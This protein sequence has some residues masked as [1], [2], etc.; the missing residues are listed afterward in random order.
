MVETISAIDE[1]GN[2]FSARDCWC[3]LTAS[4]IRA[5]IRDSG[6]AEYVCA[7]D[8]EALQGLA[9]CTQLEGITP[10]LESSHAILPAIRGG[11]QLSCDDAIV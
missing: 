6:R 8:A 5:G 3:L 7:S 10:A 4:A 1:S 9:L 11:G 2:R